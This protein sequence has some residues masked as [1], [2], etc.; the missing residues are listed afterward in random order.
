LRAKHTCGAEAEA[1]GNAG[2]KSLDE[3]VG[4]LDQLQRRHTP[5][6]C[7]KFKVTRTAAAQQR[8]AAQGLVSLARGRSMRMTSAPI[9][10]SIMAQNGAGPMPANSITLKPH[11]TVR[12]W[13]NPLLYTGSH[14]PG[15]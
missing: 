13:P 11:S 7:F 9:S 3:N 6:G 4:F 5:S 8:I 12:S 15:A 1:L 2:A 10:A 14:C